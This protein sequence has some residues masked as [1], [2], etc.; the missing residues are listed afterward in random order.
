MF[1]NKRNANNF[2]PDAHFM[3]DLNLLESTKS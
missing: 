3:I 2:P 1:V